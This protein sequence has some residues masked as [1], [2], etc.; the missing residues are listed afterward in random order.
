MKA[1]LHPPVVAVG[2]RELF[3]GHCEPPGVRFEGRRISYEVLDQAEA[4]QACEKD[5]GVALT[6]DS[7]ALRDLFVAELRFG[8]DDAQCRGD[9]VVEAAT[10]SAH[11]I[12]CERVVLGRRLR[13]PS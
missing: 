8:C 3:A 1:S 4:G 11:Q 13:R 5:R 10:A 2:C 7:D 12:E 9:A 6:V